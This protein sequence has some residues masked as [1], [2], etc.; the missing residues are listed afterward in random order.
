MR[1]NAKLYSKIISIVKPNNKGVMSI[2]IAIVTLSFFI[3]I[4]F[5]VDIGVH[6]TN[7]SKVERVAYSLASLFRERASLYNGNDN[8]NEEDV[9]TLAKVAN[10]LLGEDLSK[11]ASLLVEGL[12]FDNINPAISM[13]NPILKEPAIQSK[14][15]PLSGMGG[16]SCSNQQPSIPLINLKD[17]SIWSQDNRWTTI[18]RISLCIPNNSKLS[19]HFSDYVNTRPKY[20]IVSD[21]VLAR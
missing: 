14:L 17:M 9:N 7:K 5:A 20:Y 18:Y 13:D 3:V 1:W 15:V 11:G 21:T 6:I 19:L 16:S 2:E 10:V 12:Y 4:F 8:I